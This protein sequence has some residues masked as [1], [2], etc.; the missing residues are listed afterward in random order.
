MPSTAQGMRAHSVLAMQ[1][2]TSVVERSGATTMMGLEK[3]LKEAAQSLERQGAC[4]A[5]DELDNHIN[6]QGG[7][8]VHSWPWRRCNETAISLKAGCQL[9]LRYTTRTSAL[10]LEDF[11]AAKARIIQARPTLCAMPSTQH[12]MLLLHCRRAV[13]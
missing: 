11:Q 7:A 6:R 4:T 13:A 1:A 3:E 2:L 10:D 12:S 8:K 5:V 9:F